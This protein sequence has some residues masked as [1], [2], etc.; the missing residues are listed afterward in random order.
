VKIRLTGT[1]D[2]CDLLAG[3]LAVRL[4]GLADVVEVS[5]FYLNRGSAVLGRVYV[6]LRF[7]AAVE[8]QVAE[9]GFW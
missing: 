9:R 8:R 2:E 1:R 5:S 6:E 4:S 7:T 3:H